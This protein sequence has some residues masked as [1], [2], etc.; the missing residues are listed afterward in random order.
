MIFDAL[1]AYSLSHNSC[2]SFKRNL[3]PLIFRRSI[4]SASNLCAFLILKLGFEAA[5]KAMTLFFWLQASGAVFLVSKAEE[6]KML[7]RF[8][9]RPRMSLAKVWIPLIVKKDKTINWQQ[10]SDFERRHYQRAIYRKKGTVVFEDRLPLI[11]AWY[12]KCC[13]HANCRIQIKSTFLPTRLL[14]INPE[15][16]LVR[17]VLTKELKKSDEPLKYATLS[18]RWGNSDML[19]T[20]KATE[21]EFLEL[22][23]A[24]L[25]PKSFRDAIR[26]ARSLHLLY[27]WIDS[28]C[29]VQDDADDWKREAAQMGQIY[30]TS[31]LSIAA[32]DSMD[33]NGGCF[34]DSLKPSLFG[35]LTMPSGDDG[36][37]SQENVIKCFSLRCPIAHV[38]DV[39]GSLLNQRGW[40]SQETML[41]PR[42]LFC[43][44][45]QF[46]FQCRQ[47]AVSED[48]AQLQPSPY[49]LNTGIS[50]HDPLKPAALSPEDG[51]YRKLE[52]L[53][54]WWSWV[55][56]YSLRDFTQETDRLPAT[57]G[58]VK[59]YQNSTSFRPVL[60]MWVDT[61]FFDL[62]WIIWEPENNDRGSYK[63][64]EPAKIPN[65]PSWSWLP[66]RNVWQLGWRSSTSRVQQV[67]LHVENV[68][69]IWNDIPLTS[70]IRSTTL[71]VTSQ[72]MQ[73][74]LVWVRDGFEFEE[75]PAWNLESNQHEADEDP[76]QVNFFLDAQDK[77]ASTTGTKLITHLGASD[78]YRII[79][80]SPEQNARHMQVSCLFLHETV[81]KRNQNGISVVSSFFFFLLLEKQKVP[82][83]VE[84]RRNAQN[85]YRRIGAG[86]FSFVNRQP[87]SRCEDAI[88][89]APRVTIEII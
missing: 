83:G 31:S 40:V 79:L 10:G 71:I 7:M 46:Y 55:K 54:L 86:D 73:C 15:D 62:S 4:A 56:D 88:I 57:A 8:I 3:E 35:N 77:S 58:V 39:S 25:I 76:S 14:Y 42:I 28:L 81:D 26:I 61:L 32:M 74:T 29:I 22:V 75:Y 2:A 45:N 78:Y 85:L 1:S 49:S 37:D 87:K 51:L 18:H 17:L 27:I 6:I 13:D 52:A 89:H 9:L 80:D 70:G 11:K 65:C 72:M 69:V 60:G 41:A 38:N 16:D 24:T 64:I 44:M 5:T 47:Q 20:L 68:D 34:L 36:V 21:D 50:Y 59:V 53:D 84:E 33:C 23:P 48:M 82:A 12:D 63:S 30:E 43:G 66:R 67:F 19:K